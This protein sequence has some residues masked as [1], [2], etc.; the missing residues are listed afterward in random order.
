MQCLRSIY[1]QVQQTTQLNSHDGFWQI[2]K[3]TLR[4]TAKALPNAYTVGF[5]LNAA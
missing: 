4:A 3:V 5:D 2:C 1:H